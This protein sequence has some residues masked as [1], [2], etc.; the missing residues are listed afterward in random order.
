MLKRLGVVLVGLA[1]ATSAMEARATPFTSPL[2]GIAGSESVIPSGVGPLGSLAPG[3]FGQSIS[4]RNGDGVPY[5]IGTLEMLNLDPFPLV[6]CTGS[7]PFCL[8]GPQG[9]E[10]PL[11]MTIT[12]PLALGARDLLLVFAGFFNNSFPSTCDLSPHQQLDAWIQPGSVSGATLV[13][14]VNPNGSGTLCDSFGP[15][16]HGL[17]IAGSP[18]EKVS[19]DFT[20]DVEPSDPEI[21]RIAIPLAAFA[22]T[23]IPEPTTSSLLALGLLGLAMRRRG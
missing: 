9:F 13:D 14:V 12:L 3:T 15:D 4:F 23:P 6:A 21:T 19:I 5:D 1:L 11:E 7:P 10:Q 16:L 2:V 22:V 20:L 17:L 8:S 18:G